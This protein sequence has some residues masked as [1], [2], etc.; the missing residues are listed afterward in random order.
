MEP[1]QNSQFSSVEKASIFLKG[2]P[3][4]A[5]TYKLPRKNE[6]KSWDITTFRPDPRHFLNKGK[7]YKGTIFFSKENLCD[8]TDVLI[9]REI[10]IGKNK[11][12]N[13]IR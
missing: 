13:N 2:S 8:G 4:Y 12:F 6:Q 7:M 11:K 5:L 1:R 3:V 9:P 10:R